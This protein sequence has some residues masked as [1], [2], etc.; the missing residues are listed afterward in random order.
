MLDGYFNIDIAANPSAKRAP[1]M[2]SD[3]RA[4]A[5]PD[6]CANEIMAIHLWEHL[7]RWEC[8]AVIDEWFRLLARKGV[9]VLE[10]PD[11][12]KFC[13][14]ILEGKKGA[15]EP[16][17]LGMWGLYGDPTLHDPY[18][19]HRWGWT[20]ATIQPFLKAHGFKDIEEQVP[21][22]HKVGRFDRDFRVVA[23]KP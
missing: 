20:F 10:M 15:K 12:F 13:A 5:L 8:D 14:N 4:I 19:C 6:G 9:L 16:D 11:L 3:V 7:Y 18:M 1:E 17:Q 2:L 21:Q 23:R 22:W